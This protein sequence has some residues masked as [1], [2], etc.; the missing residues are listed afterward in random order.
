MLRTIP[1]KPS[2]LLLR[3]Q[4][5]PN[6][7]AESGRALAYFLISRASLSATGGAVFTKTL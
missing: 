2:M 3:I 7:P 4:T 6:T 1:A 5:E